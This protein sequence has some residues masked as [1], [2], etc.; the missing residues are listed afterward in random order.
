MISNGGFYFQL[1]TYLSIL[2]ILSWASW[3]SLSYSAI[4]PVIFLLFSK[5]NCSPRL[6]Y[7]R[8]LTQKKYWNA[9]TG[10]CCAPYP[11]PDPPLLGGAGLRFG[12]FAN[13]TFPYL[14]A[15]PAAWTLPFARPT[16]ART[17]FAA[18]S[19]QASEGENGHFHPYPGVLPYCLGTVIF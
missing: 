15:V 7:S 4:A 10:I 13:P 2:L 19:N 11:T 6:T 18:E 3:R 14:L 12:C 5:M 17:G 1:V 16:V 9:Q 8:Q